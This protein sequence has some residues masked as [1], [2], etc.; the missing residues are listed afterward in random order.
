MAALGW[1]TAVLL[2]VGLG[3]IGIMKLT[4]NKEALVQAERLGYLKIMT[5]IGVAEVTAAIAVIVGVALSDL[6]WVGTIAAYGII[7]MMIGASWYHH[8]AKDTFERAPSLVMI[9]LAVGYLIAMT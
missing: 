3:G 4:R 6:A 1:V 5:P 9:L 7:A 8:R 2:L